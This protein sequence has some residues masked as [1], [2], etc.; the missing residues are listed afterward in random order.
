MLIGQKMLHKNP[1]QRITIPEMKRHPFF[2]GINWMKLMK[3]EL[4]PPIVL[5]MDDSEV[6]AGAD[7]EEAKFLKQLDQ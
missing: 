6:E 5:R 3:R 7:P 1:K 2:A 4:S